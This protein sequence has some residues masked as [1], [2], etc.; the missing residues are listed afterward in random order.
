MTNVSKLNRRHFLL[1][2][3]GL[4]LAIPTLSSLIPRG[5]KAQAAVQK[6]MVAMCTDHGG[7]FPRNMYPDMPAGSSA[8]TLYAASGNLARHDVRYGALSSRV[9]GA[10]RII[11]NCLR[12]PSSRFSAGL[13]DKLN[14]MT[15]F[16]ITT[17][18]GHN[19]AS[20][21]GNY[22]A[23]DQG[24]EVQGIRYPTIDQVIGNASGF[25]L[26]P[27]RAPTINIAR[28]YGGG[29]SHS[30]A[31]ALDLNLQPVQP[32]DSLRPL[33]ALVAVDEPTA[34]SRPPQR[35]VQRVYDH[36]R[37]LTTGA[38]G[39]AGRLS[40][41]DRDRL[42][43]HMDFLNAIEARME[44]QLECG[45]APAYNDVVS[46]VE[47]LRMATDLIA[48]ALM[49]GASNV[50]VISAPGEA[51]AQDRNYT[52][53]H[54]QIAHNGG[55]NEASAN[56]DYQRTNYRS[57]QQFFSEVFVRLAEHLNVEESTGVTFLDNSLLYWTMESGRETHNNWSQPVVTAGS[58]GGFFHTGRFIDYRNPQS[59]LQSGVVLNQ[60]LSNVLQS[61]G[62]ARSVFNQQMQR[63]QPAQAAAGMKGYGPVFWH[64]DGFWS[65]HNIQR[66]IWP[67]RYYRDAD[68][69]LKGWA[70]GA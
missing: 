29:A 9:E 17:Y 61:M 21:M 28:G 36:Y 48:M 57:H 32:T 49:C 31:H 67:E 69:H 13:V 34:P 42:T 1:G 39:D 37:G 10:D 54:E 53:W 62:V 51:F 25:N 63:A 26:S 46:T 44:V 33:L 18:L 23:N 59:P 64:P 4:A 22:S 58:A 19:A 45:D 41:D 11:S 15:G 65:G 24:V 52:D 3:G 16:D 47:Q 5:A 38:F 55:G 14:V 66:D 20:F 27:V 2:T 7:V 8:E 43:R 35:L 50:A 6:R 12:A 40:R 70:V 68:N 56:P 60:F 30:N